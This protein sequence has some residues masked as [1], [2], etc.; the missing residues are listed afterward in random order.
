MKDK[1]LLLDLLEADNEFEAIGILAQ[2]GLF[3]DANAHR[4]VELGKMPNNQSVV[5]AQQSSPAAALVEKFTNG[6][7]A[8]LMRHCKARDINP[9]SVSAPQTMSIAVSRWIGDLSE[10]S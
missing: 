4:W 7:D 6:L 2:R 1:R 8:I 9:R 5:H 3:N 10:K